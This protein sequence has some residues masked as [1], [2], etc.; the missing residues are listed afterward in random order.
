MKN[1]QKIK[2]YKKKY[3]E[4]NAEKIKLYREQN[5]EKIKELKHKY[6]IEHRDEINQ[7]AREKYAEKKLEKL[8][9]TEDI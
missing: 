6:A 9:S 1:D 3:R 4:E 5:A 8:K 2:D 7:K